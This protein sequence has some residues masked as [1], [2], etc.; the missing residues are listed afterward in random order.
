[1]KKSHLSSKKGWGKSSA[2]IALLALGVLVL[3]IFSVVS[4]KLK[5]TKQQAITEPEAASCY[6]AGVAYCGDFTMYG[7]DQCERQPGC[8]WYCPAASPSS[9][10]KPT[11]NLIITKC[12]VG[13]GA[14]TCDVKYKWNTDAR[15][16]IVCN[17]TEMTFDKISIYGDNIYH[18]T[19]VKNCSGSC[20][21]SAPSPLGKHYASLHAWYS[22][23]TNSTRCNFILDT[24]Y[25]NITP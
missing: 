11:G 19:Q 2:F 1:M 14:S 15:N 9:P 13:V 25:F 10:Y 6:C 23:K 22:N 3:S 16:N 18:D 7:K 24:E 12:N 17:S 4:T 5:S 21:I 8:A 20:Y